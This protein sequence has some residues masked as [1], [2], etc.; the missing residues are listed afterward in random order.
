MAA[1]IGSIEAGKLADLVVIDGDV[2]NNLERSEFVEYTVLNGRIYEA[3]TMNELGD[4][5]TRK[6]FFFESD[7]KTFMPEATSQAIEQKSHKYHW[8]HQ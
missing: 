2:L 1:D 8:Q 5:K 7:N 3:A 4:D 6:P